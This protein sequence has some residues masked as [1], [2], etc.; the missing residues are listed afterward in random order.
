[1]R[2]T[3][4]RAFTSAPKTWKESVLFR[5][6]WVFLLVAICSLF[7]FHSMQKKGRL[8]AELERRLQGLELEKQLALQTREDFLLQISSQ[9]DPA[10]IQM[11]LMK[12]LG[13][14]PEGQLK[15][16]FKKED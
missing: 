3:Y 13:V 9:S 7:Y 2:H 14:V 6:W 8:Y 10:W 11:T 1:M 5:S 12:G 15:I 16:Y 4:T